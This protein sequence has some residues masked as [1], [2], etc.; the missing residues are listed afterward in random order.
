MTTFGKHDAATDKCKTLSRMYHTSAVFPTLVSFP[1]LLFTFNLRKLEHCTASRCQ[2]GIF[3]ILLTAFIFLPRT[4][5]EHKDVL[6][7]HTGYW[8]RKRDRKIRVPCLFTASRQFEFVIFPMETGW[9]HDLALGR[10][11][12]VSRNT[13]FRHCCAVSKHLI[14]VE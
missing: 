14:S 2:G 1:L 9:E 7:F 12:L 13:L 5:L 10:N 8:R 6:V 3:N 4:N 11:I